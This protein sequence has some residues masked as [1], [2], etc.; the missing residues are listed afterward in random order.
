MLSVVV[1]LFGVILVALAFVEYVRLSKLRGEIDELK[2][3]LRREN[4]AIQKGMQCVIASYAI[5]DPDQKIALLKLAIER[6]PK[7]FNA[8][9]S[10]GYAWLEK[11]EADKAEAA[12]KEAIR[13]HPDDKAGYFDLARLYLGQQKLRKA[14]LQ[15]GKAIRADA[16]SADD[17]ADDA[18]LAELGL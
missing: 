9:N 4:Y 18:A 15:L 14:R 16:T 1:A 10:L 13:A 17:I 5:K 8:W 7:T 3:E 11:E 2:D 6:H 12:F